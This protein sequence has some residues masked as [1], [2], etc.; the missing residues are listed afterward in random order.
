M[1]HGRLDRNTAHGLKELRARIDAAGIPSSALDETINIATWNIRAFGK[2]G[3][4]DAALHY[5]A[6]IINS[7][8]VV[9]ITELNEN[10]EDLKKVMCILGPYWKVVYSDAVPDPAGNRERI[11]FIYDGRALRFSGLAA[12]A[13]PKRIRLRLPDGQEEVEYVRPFEWWR[14]PYL[15]SFQ[16]G[17]FDFILL[18]AHI[19]WGRSIR[20]RVKELHGLAEWVHM[21]RENPHVVDRDMIV[22]GDFNVTS[23]RS[24]TYKAITEYGLQ[25]APGLRRDEFGTDLAR[26][27]RY[28]QIMHYPLHD[29]LYRNLKGEY[30][31][32]AGVLDFY[33]GDHRPLFPEQDMG[34]EEFTFQLSDHLPLWMQLNIWDDDLRLDQLLGG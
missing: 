1:H 15:V 19:R 8:D 11:G 34:K 12:E 14:S 21:R 30:A 32:P 2:N 25:V 23:R 20:K 31:A 24:G 29:S 3:R 28:D 22:L 7:F 6:E 33:Q 10:L 16:A 13:D 4:Q 26:G 18:A 5:I 17:N 9:A 27:K